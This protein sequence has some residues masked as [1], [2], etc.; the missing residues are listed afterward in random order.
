MWAENHQ[1]K[2]AAYMREW[3][4]TH[5]MNAEQRRKDNCRSYAKEYLKRGHLTREQ[6][7]L[8]DANAAEMHH[9]DYAEPLKVVWLC[10]KHHL[11]IHKMGF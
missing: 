9:P 8:C 11:A 7:A 3:R 2:H 10:R 4:K 5:P 1:A 6:C